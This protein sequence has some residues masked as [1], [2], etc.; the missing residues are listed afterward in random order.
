M[1]QG[2]VIAKIATPVGNEYKDGAHLHLE[3]S[4]NGANADP[5]DYLTLSE[6]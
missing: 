3:M 6:K 2:Q 4:V 1:T 5:A